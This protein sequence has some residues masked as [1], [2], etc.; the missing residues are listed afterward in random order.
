MKK[1]NEKQSEKWKEEVAKDLN[2]LIG[3]SQV[4]QVYKNVILRT[5]KRVAEF[6]EIE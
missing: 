5:I 3:L 1:F 2:K 6:E 4:T